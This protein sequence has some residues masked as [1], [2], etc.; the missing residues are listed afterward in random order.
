MNADA[1]PQGA[2]FA[3]VIEDFVAVPRPPLLG[4]ARVRLPSGMI[5]HGVGLYRKDGRE[6]AMP[7][8]KPILNRDGRHMRG[9]DGKLRFAPIIE[10][11]TCNAKDRFSTAVVDAVRVAR[12]DLFGEAAT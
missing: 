4:F 12:P 8:G 3:L 10:F 7:P 9:D 2:T 1:I 11:T 6:W 5:V